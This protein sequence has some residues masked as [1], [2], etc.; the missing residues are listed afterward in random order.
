M[1]VRIVKLS[2]A[3]EKVGQ[4]L[5]S[6]DDVKDRIRS[7]QGCRHMELLTDR[8]NSGV[9]FTYSTWDGITDLENYRNSELFRNTWLVVKPMFIAKAEA[10]TVNKYE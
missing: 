7:F 4:F 5:K 6:F 3:P 1:I 9:V 10:W 8:E 2:L